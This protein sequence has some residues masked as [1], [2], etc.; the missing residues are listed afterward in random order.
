[1][2]I[3]MRRAAAFG[4][5]KEHEQKYEEVLRGQ[6]QE[7]ERKLGGLGT[8]SLKKYYQSKFLKGVLEQE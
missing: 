5:L 6:R 7:R 8:G 4:D 2:S 1:M 3:R